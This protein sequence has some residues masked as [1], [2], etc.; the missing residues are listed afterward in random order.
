MDIEIRLGDRVSERLRE[1][2]ETQQWLVNRVLEL[3]PDL[4]N[5]NVGNVHAIIKRKQT[6]S[7]YAAQMAAALGVTH[8][9]LTDGAHP[10]LVAD[11]NTR[12]PHAEQDTE[13]YIAG[14]IVPKSKRQNR[15]DEI[16]VVAATISDEGL[17]VLVYKAREIAME[18]PLQIKQ[19]HK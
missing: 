9:W 8:T 7:I 3:F 12:Y 17:A 5:F 16:G 4:V 1:L 18:H 2:G 19:T 11:S 15:I 14:K 6:S 13:H 10:K